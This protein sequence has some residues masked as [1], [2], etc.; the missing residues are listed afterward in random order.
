MEVIMNRY[1]KFMLTAVAGICIFTT[2]QA[3][4]QNID[5]ITT[6]DVFH[7]GKNKI[8]NGYQAL[9]SFIR[10]HIPQRTNFSTKNIL[11]T[12]NNL[13]TQTKNIATYKNIQETLKTEKHALWLKKVLERENLINPPGINWKNIFNK[14]LGFIKNKII[15]WPSKTHSNEASMPTTHVALDQKPEYAN[16]TEQMEK[17]ALEEK[18]HAAR[19]NMANI[20]S[21]DTKKI[22]DFLTEPISSMGPHENA[23]AYDNYDNSGA[24]F[25]SCQDVFTKLET[26]KTIIHPQAQQCAS[27]FVE[28]QGNLFENLK[29]HLLKYAPKGALNECR[30]MPTTIQDT[31]LFGRIKNF[32]SS[33]KYD[34]QQQKCYHQIYDYLNKE[35]RDGLLKLKPE[36]LEKMKANLNPSQIKEILTTAGITV[37]GI[38][39]AGLGAYLL[40]KTI[41]F[42]WRHKGIAIP[43]L[44]IAALYMMTR[45][46]H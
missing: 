7:W 37:A 26:G 45:T 31:S 19:I 28:L 8:V 29:T 20:L 22:T 16:L 17:Y 35:E 15:F 43:L 11:T 44:T 4:K 12:I 39:A 42:G 46:S 40:Y 30:A 41:Q 6:C 32:A 23:E 18:S 14:A 24:F 38:A 1:S 34:N 33:Y 25:D 21:N 36:D 13:D 2:T 3:T 27:K 10:N 5:D 9:S